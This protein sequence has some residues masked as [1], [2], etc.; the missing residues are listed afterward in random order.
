[1]TKLDDQYQ[2]MDQ[3]LEQ[4][5]RCSGDVPVGCVVVRD[6]LVIGSGRNQREALQDPTAHAE[7]LALRQ[8]ASAIKSWR[9]EGCSIYVTLEPCAMCAEAIIQSRLSRLFFGAYEQLTGA[10]GSRFNL[11]EANRSLPLPEVIG[12]IR[13]EECRRMLQDF[14]RQKRT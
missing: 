5:N 7:M 3:A 9:L 2:W 12:G 10:A 14:F 1:M 8:A 11:F 13:E 4:A 6:G